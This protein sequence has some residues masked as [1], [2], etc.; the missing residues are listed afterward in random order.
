METKMN[1]FTKIAGFRLIVILLFTQ[2]ILQG[3]QS[4]PNTK[5][6]RHYGGFGYFNLSAET[7]AFS[8]LNAILAKAG[9][10]KINNIS[11]A[12]GGGGFFVLKNFMIGGGG[13]WIPSTRTHNTDNTTIMSGGYGFTSFGYLFRLPGRLF[14]FPG[15]GLGGGGYS[16]LINPDRKP[17][18]FDEQVSDPSGMLF[19][20]SGGWMLN[21]S[22]TCQRF[23]K[24]SSEGFFVALKAGYKYSPSLWEFRMYDRAI[25][26]SPR[27]NMNGITLSL[28]FGGGAIQ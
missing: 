25:T 24:R 17:L 1:F 27:I 12:F 2:G 20:E 4:E 9:Y 26:N 10:E 19:L 13:N 6:K 8:E 14:V 21:I 3:Q 11:H 22:L 5:M 16:L 18:N 23:L 28:I 15:I 7:A